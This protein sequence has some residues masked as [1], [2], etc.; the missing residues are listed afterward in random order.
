M[1]IKQLGKTYSRIQ[2]QMSIII[3]TKGI[4]RLYKQALSKEY[5]KGKPKNS[6]QGFCFK[7]LP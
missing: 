5:T 6:I 7:M 2:S 1:D 3:I 4:S